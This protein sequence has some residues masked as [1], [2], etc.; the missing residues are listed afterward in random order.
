[1]FREDALHDS[2]SERDLR[3]LKIIGEYHSSSQESELA[4]E[5]RFDRTTT[6]SGAARWQ[7][8]I[9]HPFLDAQEIRERQQV[10]TYLIRQTKLRNQLQSELPEADSFNDVGGPR[11]RHE[12]NGRFSKNRFWMRNIFFVLGVWGIVGWT[13]GFS[14]YAVAAFIL[15]SALSLWNVSHILLRENPESKKAHLAVELIGGVYETL[16][17]IPEDEKPANLQQIEQA[18]SAAVDPAHADSLVEFKKRLSARALYALFEREA[19][20]TR[21]KK[22]FGAIGEL[23]AY[24]SI[25][26]MNIDHEMRTMP[27]IL[28]GDRPYAQFEDVT[29][30]AFSLTKDFQSANVTFDPSRNGLYLVTA[31]NGTGKSTLI[32]TVALTILF[33]Q[34]GSMAA[35]SSIRQ[36]PLRLRSH[37]NVEDS[38]AEGESRFIAE[39]N[40]MSAHVATFSP[41]MKTFS[42]PATK[43]SREPIRTT[44]F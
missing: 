44:D 29:H 16:H 6:R 17:A 27:E 4:I 11:F 5:T 19:M 35:G 9:R 36:T 21:F 38:L 39:V 12:V 42:L 37:I 43:F 32:R 34:I 33:D 20:A 18:L 8:L 40:L 1:M 26:Q 24:Q 3:D 10:V 13:Q 14:D 31:P 25:A 2:L 41:N 28:D 15:Y 23:D 7:W 22:V 30:P